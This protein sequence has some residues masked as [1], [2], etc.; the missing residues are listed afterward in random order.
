[1]DVGPHTDVLDACP[2]ALGI[3]M[4]LRAMNPQI[5]AV[6]EITAAMDCDA[7]LQAGWCGVRLLATAHAS[8]L[9][10]LNSRPLYRPLL[11][12]KLFDHFIV[13]R[14]DKTWREERMDL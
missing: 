4:L 9:R 13:L 2:K 12:S 6:D 1:M 5:I 3:P 14:R 11:E 7:L 10:D 8:S